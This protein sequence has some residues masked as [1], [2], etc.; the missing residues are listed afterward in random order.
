MSHSWSVVG[1]ER[2]GITTLWC[3]RCG[4][5][6]TESGTREPPPWTGDLPGSNPPGEYG[7]PFGPRDR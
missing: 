5:E 4:R 3:R 6:R 2:D 7:P 1:D